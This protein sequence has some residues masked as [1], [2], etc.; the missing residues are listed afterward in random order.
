MPKPPLD[1]LCVGPQRTATSWLHRYLKPHP[2]VWLPARVKE[3][4]FF[5]EHYDKGL[6]WYY[7]HF[8]GCDES[9]LRGEV[10]PTYFDSNQALERVRGF[11]GMRVVILV[12]DPIE[13]TYSLFRHHRTKGRVADDYFTAVRAMPRIET[14]GRYAEHCPK[15]EDAF[16]TDNCLYLTQQRVQDEP[17]AEFDRLC[18]FLSI[19]PLPLPE[20]ASAPF[21]ATTK[22][23]NSTVAKFGARLSTA[24]RSRG[25]HGPI[26]LAKKMGVRSLVFGKPAGDEAISPDVLE[27]LKKL[28]KPD[29]TYLQDKLGC[30][31]DH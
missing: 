19:D 17:Q 16:G 31:F 29:L 21:G 28:H 30:E 5:D 1:F 15:W 14:S 8:E 22:P 10:A 12:R 11:D 9:R 18:T 25:L 20:E 13:R 26:E 24:M 23:P 7:A 3:T 2:G 27:H 6:A 4:M